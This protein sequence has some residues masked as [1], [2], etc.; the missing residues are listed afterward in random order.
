MKKWYLYK[1]MI[2]L[3]LLLMLL[4]TVF[5]P[6]HTHG[7][8]DMKNKVA[9]KTYKGNFLCAENGGGS[10]LV[11]DRN[12]IGDWEI[13]EIIDLGKGYIALKGY[14][15]DYLKVDDED[16]RVNGSKINKKEIFQ[17]VKLD[18]NKVAFKAYNKKY[19]SA[20]D[21]GGD[22]VSVDRT[23]IGNWES[24]E[25]I[26]IQQKSKIVLST[27]AVDR[28]IDLFWT[29][30][31][32]SKD[33]IGYNLYRATSA[34]KQS[35]T[36]ITDFPI[37]KTYY[38]DLNIEDN[39]VYYYILRPVYKDKTIGDASNEVSIKSGSLNK[40]I[41]LQLGSKYMFVNNEKKEIDPGKGTIMIIKN[42]RTFLPIRAVIEEMGGEVEWRQSDKRVSIY[43][44]GTKIY[45]WIGNKN[46]KVNGSTKET[47][48]AP[49]ISD[50]E[51]TML[52]LRFI[53]ENLDCDV[54]WDGLTKKVT[55]KTNN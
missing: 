41:V 30:P 2:T 21:G 48:V 7:H 23:K 27:I 43:L 34:G 38:S 49:Y 12:Q 5:S 29:R 53:A 26:D 9:I 17:L 46:A 40:S 33:I 39:T 35:K 50:S 18:N 24:F 47:D 55:I 45:L 31:N 19:I 32:F 10:K 25:L 28:G 42:G 4:F 11:A 16:V 22:A 14:N 37:E 36:P 3:V 8:E 6:N 44:K 20:E 52:P 13:F 1:K 54:D 51:R 15:G